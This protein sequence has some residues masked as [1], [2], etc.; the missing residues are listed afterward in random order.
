[1]KYRRRNQAQIQRIFEEKTGVSVSNRGGESGIIRKK[2][3]VFAAATLCVFCL[4]AFAYVRFS[5][6]NGD[7][8]KLESRY[9]GDGVFEIVITNL[10][11]RE[12]ELQKSVKL[13]RWS[14]AQEAEGDPAKIKMDSGIIGPHSQGIV[15]IDLSEGYDIARLEEELPEGD[16][17]YLMLTNNDFAFGQDWI[18]DIVFDR[19]HSAS[20]V[21]GP[22][23]TP[24]VKYTEDCSLVY[25]D[26][27]WPTVSRAVSAVYGEQP[28]G[29][30]SDHINIVGEMGDEVYA[31]ADGAV[32]E[33]GFESASGN[34]I[35]LEL[36]NDTTVKYGHLQKIQVKEGE[37]VSQ[38]EVIGTLGKS[39]TATGP[40]L[41]LKVTVDGEAVNPLAEQDLS[42]N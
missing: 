42:G 19:E 34:Y 3:L 33:T 12:L 16:W 4:S 28:N 10:S 5:G 14:G 30:R 7:R 9:Q 24:E 8:L 29:N 15:R 1:M 26:W 2:G 37:N 21:Y 41:A 23:A 35:I 39:G 40:N 22:E 13:M 20:V 6:L 18:C 31:V 38:G 11:G 36:E 25:A 17:Y 27:T 32:L